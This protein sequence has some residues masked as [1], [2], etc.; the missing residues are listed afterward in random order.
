M[1]VDHYG[2]GV[3]DFIRY[4]NGVV[5]P[6]H[7]AQF[8]AVRIYNLE[9]RED[10]IWVVSYPK[11]GTTLTLE[12]VWMIVNGEVIQC[13]KPFSNH[14]KLLQDE[15]PYPHLIVA[16]FSP[17]HLAASLWNTDGDEER[18]G[19]AHSAEVEEEAA[20]AELGE[21]EAGG[22][23]RHE[24]HQEVGGDGGSLHH[25]LQLGAEPLRLS[26]IHI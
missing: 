9:V 5:L 21:D 2:Q 26:L 1:E 23:H 3:Y 14:D 15:L 24:D 12:M 11:K 22:L 4:E 8:M 7:Y 13:K 20:G 17:V 6:R 16:L 18:H 25:R 10:D 19:A